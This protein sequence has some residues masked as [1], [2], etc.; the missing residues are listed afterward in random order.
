MITVYEIG[1]VKMRE[2]RLGDAAELMNVTNDTDVMKYYGME[3]YREI[4]EAEAEIEWFLGLFRDDSGGRWVIADTAS[5]AYIGDVGI[6]PLNRRHHRIE[7]GFKLRKEYWGR[8]IMTACI[9]HVLNYGF[10]TKGYNRIE[11]V[12]DPRNEG[13]KRTLVKCGFQYEGLLRE[14]EAEHGHYVDLGMYSILR[15]EFVK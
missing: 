2:P 4:K 3:P 10:G 8:G 6:G 7:I 9:G 13:S 1:S 14:Y 11:A 12:V 15:R 5:D